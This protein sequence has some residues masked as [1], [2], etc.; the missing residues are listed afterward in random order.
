MSR[1][2]LQDTITSPSTGIAV[3][4]ATITIR[5]TDGSGPLSTVYTTRAGTTEANNPLSTGDTGLGADGFL[6]VYLEPGLYFVEVDTGGVTR[7]YEVEAQGYSA[8][9]DSFA[10]LVGGANQLPYFTGSDALGQTPLSAFGR[11]L[12]DDSGA[13][14]ARATL[15]LGTAATATLTTSTEDNTSG[16]VLRVDDFGIGAVGNRI[17]E[18]TNFSDGFVSA[19]YRFNANTVVGGPSQTGECVAIVTVGANG[20]TNIITMDGANGPTRTMFFGSRNS[21]AGVISWSRVF[22]PGS[23]LGTV[24][25]S[26]GIPDG[27]LIEH[28]SNSD[29]YYTRFA[30]GTQVCWRYDIDITGL[31]A[32][33]HTEDIGYPVSFSEAVPAQPTLER[34]VGNWGNADDRR[35]FLGAIPSKNQARIV[36][37]N[38][39]GANW[40]GTT[41]RWHYTATGRWF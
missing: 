20:R 13:A 25:Q 10:N 21:N 29:G 17:P 33:S 2:A 40:A 24:S 38:D 31:A 34:S 4:S 37:L 36:F 1:V 28:D 39:G 15:N 8:K 30:D 12:I 5:D 11:S 9:L 41:G 27:A 18:I 6:S 14:S 35:A 32:N 26:G 19:T 3:P 22:H 23:V 7:S 16:R